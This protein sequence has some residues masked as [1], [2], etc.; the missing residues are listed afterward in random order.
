MNFYLEYILGIF[1]LGALFLISGYFRKTDDLKEKMKENYDLEDENYNLKKNIN[2]LKEDNKFLKEIVMEF[3]GGELTKGELIKC[4]QSLID[5]DN[6]E[7][8]ERL[9]RLQNE[10][11]EIYDIDLKE[12]DEE[13]YKK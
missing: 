8:K 2:D 13:D 4:V 3:K 12:E 11:S 1:L 7:E 9:E 5:K 6:K 10:I